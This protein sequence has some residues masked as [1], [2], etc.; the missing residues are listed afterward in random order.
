MLNFKP[1][2]YID[3]SAV[4]APTEY[5]VGLHN[6]YGKNI[7]FGS[8]S[9]SHFVDVVSLGPVGGIQEV[10][11][12]ETPLSSGEF[13]R[14]TIYAHDGN[15][16][17]SPWN[18]NFPYV[19]R[20]VSLG[21][22]AEITEVGAGNYSSTTFQRKV[23]S[24][25]VVG[26]R[27]NFT[28]AGF[29]HKDDKNR[30]KDASARF[31]IDILDSLGNT[32][33]TEISQYNK[34]SV[35]NPT[36]IQL[37]IAAPSGY[38]SFIWEYRVTMDVMGFNHSTSVSG[39]WAA[40]TATELYRDT[41][42]YDKIA[43]VS[44]TIVASDTS[45][46]IP[47]RQ[48]LAS[49]YKVLV[50]EYQDIGG[51]QVLTGTFTREVSDSPS[52]NAM[53]VITDTLWGAGQP[54]DK[55]DIVSFDEFSKYCKQIV[56][57]VPR[58]SFSQYLIKADN[59]YKLASEMVGS[60]DGR[61]YE[62]NS[63]RIG[64]LIDKQTSNRRVV[65]SYDIVDE[66][67]KRTTVAE[68]K[69]INY[70]EAEFEDRA[71]QYK[72]TIIKIEDENA[73]TKNG[74]ISKNLKLDTCT[75]LSEAQRTTKKM[76]V[77][78]Q[79]ATSSYVLKVGHTHEDVQIGEVLEVYDRKFSNVNYCG[80]V[81]AGSTLNIV[82]V[83]ART[84]I[85][86]TGIKQP[87][88]TVDNNRGL[89]IR[90]AID[91]WTSNSITLATS[92]PS[93]PAEFTSFGIDDADATGTKPTL[94]RVLGVDDSSGVLSLEGVEYNDSLYSHVENGT[95]LVVHKYKYIPAQ[96]TVD[97]T[98]LQI[99]RNTNGITAS[100]DS[101]G[102][103]YGYGYNWK[104][105]P[106]GGTTTYVG[107]GVTDNLQVSLLNPLS[108][109]TYEIQVLA[110]LNGE[111][112][113]EYAISTIYINVE[114]GSVLPP[115]TGLASLLPDGST[116]LSFLGRSF[117]IRWDQV[118]EFS[119][120]TV[121]HF[122]LNVSQGTTNYQVIVDKS[123]RTYRFS[124]GTLSLWF[125]AYSRDFYIQ[126]VTVGTDLKTTP[127]RQISITNQEPPLPV[128]NA[129][130]PNNLLLT[131][132]NSS[133]PSDITGTMISVWRTLD[134]FEPIPPTA[135]TFFST[136]ISNIVLPDGLIP[137]DK[138][139][140]A[141]DAAWVDSFGES[142]L[143]GRKGL[144]YSPEAIV[145]VPP[146][147]TESIP[148]DSQTVSVKY[149]HEGDFLKE[150]WVFFRKLGEEE[151][152]QHLPIR[153]IP[154]ED[155]TLSDYDISTGEGYFNVTGLIRNFT[156][157]FSV[158]A[159]NAGSGLSGKSNIITG[160]PYLDVLL[161]DDLPDIPDLSDLP[162]VEDLYLSDPTTF[163][164]ESVSDVFGDGKNS[165]EITNIKQLAISDKIAQAAVIDE[166]KVAVGNN[167]ASIVEGSQALADEVSARVFSIQQLTAVVDDN[168]SSITNTQEALTTE[169]TA[170]VTAVQQLDAKVGT[171]TAN[172]TNT[173]QAL[174]T[175]TNARVSAVSN[176]TTVVNGN[177]A[178]ILSTQQA[179]STETS[180]RVTAVNNLTATVGTNTA[181][182]LSTQDALVT[183]TNARIFDVQQ[184]D[185]KVGTNTANITNAQSAIVDETSAR[186]TAIQQLT[187]QV[188]SD[189]ALVDTTAKA[190]I[191]YCTV[192]GTVS[193]HETKTACQAAGGT[194]TNSTLATA[195]RTV[196]VSSGGQ[197]ATVGSF[198]SAYVNLAGEVTG[199]AVLGVDANGAFTGMEVVGGSNYSQLTFKG[200]TIKFQNT[201]GVD[202]L[203][204][205]NA[206]NT[207]KFTGNVYAEQMI[208]DT[209]AG[210]TKRIGGLIIPAAGTTIYTIVSGDI[211]AQPFIRNL[212]MPSPFFLAQYGVSGDFTTLELIYYVN[213][214]QI[215]N[216]LLSGVIEDTASL[217]IFSTWSSGYEIPANTPVT[218]S[219]AVRKSSG[220]AGAVL[221][222]QN[223]TISI[224]RKSSQIQFD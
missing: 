69:K 200:N 85:D 137:T 192:G 24:V 139:E 216:S 205:D 144:S 49:G 28:T 34:F 170:R 7:V 113:G 64:V 201:S 8:E 210:A 135:E 93:T 224:F 127:V 32:V 16:A 90:I 217:S 158:E 164:V 203:V 52:W 37:Y 115:P 84:P 82:Q 218:F 223:Y 166:I 219:V 59:Y 161:P 120:V 29:T 72:K 131:P 60:A 99:V 43:Y 55:I 160:T 15:G 88:F 132:S 202:Q 66:V 35:K 180:A 140:Y 168:T 80:K 26:L 178:N 126:L 97:I 138:L 9:N 40:S 153:Y 83:D 73:I 77:T 1:N 105:T 207:W 173:Q 169:T 176:L 67:V 42:I 10:Y 215:D 179:L 31:R 147:L 19:E 4:T 47:K 196:Q 156:Y 104:F 23:S 12:D 11:L 212:V 53:A 98:G 184:L 48:Y 187:V 149:T 191:G 116:G 61:L 101:S 152:Q 65:T 165:T 171:N 103:G 211:P 121:S 78:S 146:E 13:P 111:S 214:N 136:G 174:V 183:E 39:N 151:W 157:E 130:N 159:A 102:A 124:E 30:N 190:A 193:S 46:K 5:V 50:P 220:S 118:E 75:R 51:T 186:V 33:S 150:I 81:A 177:T 106:V 209:A 17:S 143:H 181:A 63:G 79:V 198:Y 145:P 58:Y 22:N 117:T 163:I 38:E 25:G 119:G 162:T 154:T 95:P 62:D 123:S 185:A 44:G 112:V 221:L 2:R 195:T 20:T 129:N 109:G 114:D 175:E 96:T 14:S 54:L 167:T 3:Q 41:Q 197:S 208:G 188:A 134:P 71:N 27:V 74:V 45:G 142:S 87:L 89:P 155:P 68:E 110:T 21:K 182:I 141:V 204:F 213:G 6:V 94:I 125:G 194:W 18:N 222:N 148:I 56:D 199:K 133:L 91:S 108:E 100:W 122:K 70:V 128:I 57:G 36:A 189:I 107:S 206:T 76:L 92:L 172:I 86:L